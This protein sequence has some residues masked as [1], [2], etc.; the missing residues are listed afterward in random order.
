MKSV[1]NAAAKAKAQRE[2]PND[3]SMQKY[4]YDKI[5]Y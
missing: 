4:I 2:Y 3:Y 1:T 5:V